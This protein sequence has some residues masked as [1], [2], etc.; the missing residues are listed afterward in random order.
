MEGLLTVKARAG[1]MASADHRSREA[2]ARLVGLVALEGLWPVKARAGEMA[3][4]N[5][6]LPLG[7]C[8][9]GGFGGFG[10]FAA[11]QSACQ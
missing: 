4:A 5:P 8:E 9:V 3:N 2:W 10:G 11:G 7:L 6:S 1:E